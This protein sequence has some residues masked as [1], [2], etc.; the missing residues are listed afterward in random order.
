MGKQIEWVDPYAPDLPTCRTR[1][2]SREVHQAEKLRACGL[3]PRFI[4]CAGRSVLLHRTGHPRGNPQ[5]YQCRGQRQHA[6]VAGAAP[7]GRARRAADRVKGT[8]TAVT[9]VPRGRTID[10]DVWF[11][12]ANGARA[13]TARRRSLKPDPSKAA[14]RGAGSRPDPVID[15]R[16]RA[17]RCWRSTV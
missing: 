3:D 8:I 11:E 4:R 6:A 12:D 16:V 9:E 7:P 2:W 14:E 13:I 1:L 17:R 5:R 10:T 15:E